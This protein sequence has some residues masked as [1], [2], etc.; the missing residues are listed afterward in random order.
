[1]KYI[2]VQELFNYTWHRNIVRSAISKSD[3]EMKERTN[4]NPESPRSS[5]R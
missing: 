4:C 2:D 5:Q 3:L 1:M